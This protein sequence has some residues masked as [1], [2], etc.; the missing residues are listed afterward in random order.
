VTGEVVEG[1]GKPVKSEVQDKSSEG[2]GSGATTVDGSFNGG[3]NPLVKVAGRVVDRDGKPFKSEVQYKS[4]Q[5]SGSVAT[6]ADGLF[7]FEAPAGTYEFTVKL[8]GKAASVGSKDISSG[9][10][11]LIW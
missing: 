5:T 10:V 3:K 1:N 9:K 7:N 4:S 2:S 8:G 11:E 6:T